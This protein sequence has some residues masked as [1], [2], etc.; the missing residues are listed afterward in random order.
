MKSVFCFW[1]LFHTPAKD[2]SLCKHTTFAKQYHWK[3]PTQAKPCTQYR[4]NI[5]GKN[6]APKDLYSSHHK[7]QYLNAAPI[8]QRK[9]PRAIYI[10]VGLYS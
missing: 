1:A 5:A 3:V 10:T 6:S 7:R 9:W 8:Q 4:F 2:K